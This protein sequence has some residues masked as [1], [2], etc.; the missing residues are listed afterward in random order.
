MVVASDIEIPAGVVV[1]DGVE[2]GGNAI[3]AV[4]VGSVRVVVVLVILVVLVLV[5][6]IGLCIL[7]GS[8]EVGEEFVTPSVVV[9]ARGVVFPVIGVVFAKVVVVGS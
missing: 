5:V 1:S 6:S 4:F 8:G 2:V 9:S 3:C 7:V